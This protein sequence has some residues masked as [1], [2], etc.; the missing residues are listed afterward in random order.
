MRWRQRKNK[1]ELDLASVVSA[2]V[3]EDGAPACDII[4]SSGRIYF[5]CEIL[6]FGGAGQARIAALPAKDAE[7]AIL[8]GAGAP[9]ILGAFL[10]FDEEERYKDD[11]TL[12]NGEYPNNQIKITDVEIANGEHRF[13]ASSG[14]LHLISPASRVQGKLEISDGGAPVM[15]AALA[16]PLETL[17]ATYQA[18]IEAIVTALAA[19]AAPV[20]VPGA[21]TAAP[22]G[23][24]SSLLSVEK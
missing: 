18:R 1:A 19:A 21:P 6:I 12:T 10:S 8:K 14:G 24:A 4:D 16:E 7:I 11:I 13:V 2:Y 15:H 22:A 5:G 20:A 9:L 23:L 17:L 3:A